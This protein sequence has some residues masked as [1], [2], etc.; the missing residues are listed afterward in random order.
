MLV[1][2]NFL[3][4]LPSHV[5]LPQIHTLLFLLG[6]ELHHPTLSNFQVSHRETHWSQCRRSWKSGQ[7]P[8][9]RDF[10]QLPFQTLSEEKYHVHSLCVKQHGAFS[11][12]PQGQR[13]SSRYTKIQR[14][15]EMDVL[16]CEV[17]RCALKVFR[18]AASLCN[19][20]TEWRTASVVTLELVNPPSP[21]CRCPVERS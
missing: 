11:E 7:R 13:R 15:V 21:T 10:I 3:P 14:S 2:S 5:P 1:L 17:P 8:S 12:D 6:H 9:Q 16:H 19:A 4:L 18:K 20:R